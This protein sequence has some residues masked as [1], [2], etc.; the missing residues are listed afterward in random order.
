MV[1]KEAST[2]RWSFL[3]VSMTSEL[4][5]ERLVE[6]TQRFWWSS[7]IVWPSS[8]CCYLVILSHDFW[9]LLSK[10][11]RGVWQRLIQFYYYAYSSLKYL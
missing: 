11:R 3:R 10:R 6:D 9:R 1:A 4:A 2:S 7:V 5:R 8:G